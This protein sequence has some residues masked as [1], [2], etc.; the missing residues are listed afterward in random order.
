[1]LKLKSPMRTEN[2]L[3][4]LRGLMLY[5][6]MKTFVWTIPRLAWMRQSLR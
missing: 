1:M 6:I 4:T 2:W 5:A 3:K